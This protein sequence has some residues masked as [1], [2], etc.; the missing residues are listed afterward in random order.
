[1]NFDARTIALIKQRLDEAERSIQYVRQTL[2]D[3]DSV[4][5]SAVERDSVETYE[6]PADPKGERVLEGVFDGQNMRGNDGEQYPVPPNYA[7][8]SKLVEGDVLKLT[9]GAEGEFTYKQV[10][11]VERKRVTG[12]LVVDE[13]G[14]FGVKTP[15][16]TYRVLLAS[17]TFYK[18][19]EGDEVTVLIPENGEVEWGAV[20][21]VVHRQ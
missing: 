3:A 21:N 9:I 7:S 12:K 15:D 14:N 17:I 10:G 5:S 4:N 11:P 19:E 1:M 2:E 13:H 8:K 6:L 20:E 16:K 18:A